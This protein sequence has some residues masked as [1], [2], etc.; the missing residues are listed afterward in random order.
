MFLPFGAHQCFLPESSRSGLSREPGHPP[1]VPASSTS[2]GVSSAAE[3]GYQ[4]RDTDLTPLPPEATT[5]AYLNDAE[6]SRALPP[7]Q[8]FFVLVF[9][10]CAFI[11]CALPLELQMLFGKVEVAMS[12]IATSTL[13]NNICNSRGRAQRM[14][15]Q[16]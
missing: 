5:A 6:G 1:H 11:L 3:E 4:Y 2:A 16:P 14:N 15:A 7:Y 12:F 10:S 13:P 8:E 9:Q